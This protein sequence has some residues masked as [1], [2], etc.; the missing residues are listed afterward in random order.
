MKNSQKID[1]TLRETILAQPDVIL[2]DADVMQALVSAND[3]ARGGN[4]VDLRGVAMERLEARLDRLEDTHRSVIAA[5]Y[6]NLAGTNQ[7]HRAVLRILEPASL[8]ALLSDLPGPIADVLGVMAVRLVLETAD[9]ASTDA[10]TSLGEGVC[11][12]EPGFV[13]AY[14]G[15]T[16]D[17][18]DLSRKVL[19][20]QVE[21]GP[22]PLYGAR[23]DAVRSEACLL[24]DL[25]PD[26]LPAMLT[27]ASE[28]AQ[29][30]SPKQGT[31]LL[32]FFANAF[33]RTVRRWLA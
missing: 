24:I 18:S 2:D 32:A 17:T 12:A 14:S 8:E 3:R 6:D 1:A 10:A 25:G 19:L 7:V 26:T 13:A 5:A 21:A 23:S 4:V 22:A 29:R 30:F 33:E 31:D 16:R 11:L 15:L 28:D 9:A 20:R 27:L